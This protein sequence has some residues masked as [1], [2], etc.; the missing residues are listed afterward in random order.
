MDLADLKL[1]TL[2][3]QPAGAV[4]HLA[5][6]A[7]ILRRHSRGEAA[8]FAASNAALAAWHLLHWAEALGASTGAPLSATASALL[9]GGQLWLGLL[10]L[11]SFFHLLC[12]FE[13]LRRRRRSLRQ[14]LA[15]HLHRHRQLYVP[16]AYALPV[17]GALAWA[18]DPGGLGELLASL[19]GGIGPT[20]GYV[21]GG[22]L[23]FLA[24][25]LFPARSGQ[26]KIL[27]PA[28]GRAALLTSLGVTMGLV[29]LWHDAHPQ[30]TQWALLPWL[31]LHSV[32]FV[33]FFA[34]VRYE[35]SFMDR[36]VLGTLRLGAGA[37]VV[38][39]AY[40]AFNRMAFAGGTEARFLTSASRLSVLVAAVALA[41][42]AGA[43]VVAW[44]D[45]V[46]FARPRPLRSAARQFAL[47]I[48][49]EGSVR[50]L[51]AHLRRALGDVLHVE[52][53]Q[54]VAGDLPA[55]VVPAGGLR[56]EL[57]DRE[58]R[59]RG[60]LVLGARRNLYPWFD[61]ERAFLR[62]VATHSGRALAR[63][64]PAAE[65]P[66]SR[67]LGTRRL[68]RLELAV[69]ALGEDPA[70]D[71]ARE[72]IA[73]C[74]AHLAKAGPTTLEDEFA[75]AGDLF[76]LEQLEH[77]GGLRVELRFP[78]SLAQQELPAGTLLP[79]LDNALDH[80]VGAGGG[81]VVVRAEQRGRRCALLVEDDGPGPRGAAPL[82]GG[83]LDRL[84]QRLG[85][86]V[87]AGARIL[88]L[89]APGG[90]GTLQCVELPRQDR[91]A[92]RSGVA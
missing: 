16:V 8:V 36:Y 18:L 61:G 42:W 21:F 3:L 69:K 46:L 87:G 88:L 12:S 48:Q 19:R 13:M 1:A 25:V 29:A 74:R 47:G 52:Q 81:H 68:D 14:A 51:G 49:S 66:V 44:A 17:L 78:D 79:L 5:L 75:F 77:A 82:P 39:L 59:R 34:L 55:P 20:S 86:H 90:R 73:R 28:L 38:A 58:D 72:C 31:Q 9:A 64:Q 54:L 41:P 85:G 33:V 40:Y 27:V 84:G 80:G 65:G 10:V 76:A 45:R 63:I 92:T 62:R 57:A 43:H 35:F 7:W 70:V 11:A 53:V 91:L 30:R 6:A 2:L 26:E 23:A 22:A 4:L 15:A 89:A 60:W 24:F 37:V 67:P 56:V 32:F 71:R 83:G 50:D